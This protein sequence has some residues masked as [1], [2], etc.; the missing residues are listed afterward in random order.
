MKKYRHWSILIMWLIGTSVIWAQNTPFR[1]KVARAS[2]ASDMA[3][4][5]KQVKLHVT[6]ENLTNKA[7]ESID[8]KW[9]YVTETGSYTIV[10]HFIDGQ[11]TVDLKGMG[12]LEFDTDAV[13]I[14]ASSYGP[15]LR[16][17]WIK[18]VYNEKTIFEEFN[19]QSVQ[20]YI[21]PHLKEGEAEPRSKS[22]SGDD[23]SPPANV[24]PKPAKAKD[25]DT[26]KE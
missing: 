20:K 13:D 15:R 22:S 26:P 25:S 12:K 17:H 10:R 8:V 6:L 3:T 1:V 5:A 24:R 7:I 18:V 4:G 2:G 14:Q 19:P 9:S 16:G 23:S 11:K 21:E